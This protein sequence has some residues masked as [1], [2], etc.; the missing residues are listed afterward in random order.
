M[1]PSSFLSAQ[2]S[3]VQPKHCSSLFTLSVPV[4]IDALVVRSES[5]ETLIRNK[6]R[7]VAMPALSRR[8]TLLEADLAPRT[9]LVHLPGGV[10][11]VAPRGGASSATGTA[12]LSATAPTEGSV[13]RRI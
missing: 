12:A 3:S 11:V 6:I 1:G 2:F 8:V 5:G 10:E 13:G 9:G 4:G 7:I